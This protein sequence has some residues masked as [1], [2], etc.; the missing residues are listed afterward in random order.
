VFQGTVKKPWSFEASK[1][2]ERKRVEVNK[3]IMGD[4]KAAK[5]L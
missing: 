5:E 4:T 1:P 3:R 2:L